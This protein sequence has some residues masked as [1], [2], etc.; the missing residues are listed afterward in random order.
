MKTLITENQN[1]FIKNFA[2]KEKTT[3]NG[4]SMIEILK[5]LTMVILTLTFVLLYAAAFTGKFDPLKDNTMLLRL[6]PITFIL[7]GYYFARR[8]SQQNEQSLKDEITRQTQKADAAQ[9]SKEKAQQDCQTLEEKI[10]N[11]KATLVPAIS[12]KSGASSSAEDVVGIPNNNKGERVNQ[13]VI[14]ALKILD[15]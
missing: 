13:Y 7:I 8:P 2:M 4:K 11:V 10:K 9:Y 12:K 15:S 5:D 6:E 1:L 14:T 3:S